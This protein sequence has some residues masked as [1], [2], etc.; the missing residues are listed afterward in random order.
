MCYCAFVCPP[1]YRSI[2]SSHTL[3]AAFA[4]TDA[5]SL[6]F[7]FVLSFL[8]LSCVLTLRRDPLDVALTSLNI[9]NNAVTRLDS[10]PA[11]LVHLNASHNLLRRISGLENNY[12][13]QTLNLAHNSIHR[14]SGLD[15]CTALGELSLQC[16]EIRVI[17]DLE[18]NLNLERVD[19]SHNGI[20]TVEALRTLSLNTKVTWMCLKGNP[21]ASN[22]SYRHKLTGLLPGLVMLDDMRMPKNGYRPPSPGARQHQGDVRR[23]ASPANA[24]ASGAK[25]PMRAIHDGGAS[26]VSS[27]YDRGV[28][29]G[30]AAA[31][32]AG[33]AL[34]PWNSTHLLSSAPVRTFGSVTANANTFMHGALSSRKPSNRPAS[35]GLMAHGKSEK[36]GVPMV[37]NHALNGSRASAMSDVGGAWIPPNAKFA[38]PAVVA[39][40]GGRG[41]DPSPLSGGAV[42]S[43]QQDLKFARM[44]QGLASNSSYIEK[45]DSPEKILESLSA[46]PS[47]KSSRNASPH[48]EISYRKD[49]EVRH[50][51]MPRNAF[52]DD[53]ASGRREGGEGVYAHDVPSAALRSSPQRGGEG[54]GGAKMTVMANELNGKIERL[55]ECHVRGMDVIAQQQALLATLNRDLRIVKSAVT[56]MNA[57]MNGQ[58]PAAAAAEHGDAREDQ[59]VTHMAE[60]LQDS[61]ADLVEARGALVTAM[62]WADAAQQVNILKSLLAVH[63]TT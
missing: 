41:R 56:Y 19:L 32:A 49:H 54:R 26:S 12:D 29:S 63:L 44:A 22:I 15:Q 3:S 46:S 24:R 11:M 35:P 57:K 5:R 17:S 13:L 36:A 53:S 59:R 33:G 21:C 55:Y 23:S 25:G 1:I 48:K 62:R 9:S 10:L 2:W 60:Q 61:V 52:A 51:A 45:V 16:N 30:W 39:A 38:A 42:R 37:G 7:L 6:L 31:G 58:D 20:P 14:L 47:N 34:G 8:Y 50:A 27:S 18:C 40:L 43:S 4:W 28:A